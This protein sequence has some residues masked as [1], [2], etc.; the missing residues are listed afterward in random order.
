MLTHEELSV[1]YIFRSLFK[2]DFGNPFLP[3][4]YQ[5]KMAAPILFKKNKHFV[6]TATTRAGKSYIIS[7][8][9][10]TFAL[11]YPGSKIF[12]IA[13]VFSQAER[14]MGYVIRHLRDNPKVI[15][16]IISQNK[17][18]IEFKNGSSIEMI[19]AHGEGERLL[20]AGGDLIIVDESGLIPDDVFDEKIM[21][22]LG[23]RPDS[24]IVQLGNAI[25][26]N[27]FY[28]D[29]NDPSNTRI[30]VSWEECVKEGRLT[31][32][33]IRDQ[34]KRLTPSAF[35]M[36]YCAKFVEN[37]GDNVMP[38]SKITAC[39]DIH[40]RLPDKFKRTKSGY[41]VAGI[42]VARGGIDKTIITILWIDQGF[43]I[44]EEIIELDVNDLYKIK[45]KIMEINRKYKFEDII[46]DDIGVG[47]GLT[48][49]LKHHGLPVTPF[50]AGEK[51]SYRNEKL[52]ERKKH[53]AV[54]NVR[55]LILAE[56]LS[57]PN[58]KNLINDLA[59]YSIEYTASNKIRTIDNE[60]KSPDYGDSLV[61]ACSNLGKTTIVGVGM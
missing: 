5:V 38:L 2:D 19:S 6:I 27:H 15:S 51:P 52:F 9:A 20:S 54:W 55:E 58:N 28:R 37:I 34:K 32:D 35:D 12:L 29:F 8:T 61:L 33:F 25:R 3:Y 59:T 4:I 7:C 39:V 53:E 46:V 47:G 10:I 40:N 50:N 14:L 44:V 18:F 42:D 41:F 31:L 48:D 36:W 43:K 16:E 17:S 56:E 23:E 24:M 57:I 45:D 60:S 21:R 1:S 26:L 13:P 22:M 30:A 49:I 11:K